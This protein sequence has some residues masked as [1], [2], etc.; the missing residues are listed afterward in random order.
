MHQEL[1]D[2]VLDGGD[3]QFV[4]DRL[5]KVGDP[6][7]DTKFVHDFVDEPSYSV[8]PDPL[9][10]ILVGSAQVQQRR[11]F[12]KGSET[13]QYPEERL[14]PSFDRPTDTHALLDNV[15]HGFHCVKHSANPVLELVKSSALMVKRAAGRL[16]GLM[17]ASRKESH[18][19]L[20]AF[21]IISTIAPIA[22]R[23]VSMTR[24]G[25]KSLGMAHSNAV[26]A[27]PETSLSFLRMS[28]TISSELS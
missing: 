1:L 11:R 2:F 19:A 23:V 28:L 16:T 26:P 10:S 9:D 24:L 14:E 7:L 5:D 20:T 3:A 17:I 27:A 25:Q 15:H 13:H 6:L 22:L 21:L 8:L 4:L 12:G 18:P